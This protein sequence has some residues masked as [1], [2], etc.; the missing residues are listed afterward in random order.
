MIRSEVVSGGEEVVVSLSA[1]GEGG[2]GDESGVAGA[3]P[4]AAHAA[5][6]A[7]QPGVEDAPDVGIEG[8]GV[9]EQWDLGGLIFAP[10]M[11]KVPRPGGGVMNILFVV[12]LLKTEAVRDRQHGRFGPAAFATLVKVTWWVDE[13]YRHVRTYGDEGVAE[14][15]VGPCAARRTQWWRTRR[16]RRS[17]RRRWR[18]GGHGAG[19]GRQWP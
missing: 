4:Q 17:H 2:E 15:A 5:P 18:R 12:E 1:G 19:S 16:Q 6:Q 11:R 8:A 14:A 13:V 3:Q 10:L 9:Q 7:V